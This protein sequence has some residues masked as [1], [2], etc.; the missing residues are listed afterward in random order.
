MHIALLVIAKISIVK[1]YLIKACEK[2]DAL[3]YFSVMF[4]DIL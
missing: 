1:I 3:Q 2:N 4:S